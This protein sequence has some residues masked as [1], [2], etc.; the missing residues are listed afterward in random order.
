MITFSI[1]GLALLSTATSFGDRCTSGT[2]LLWVGIV[3]LLL[4]RNPKKARQHAAHI[5][6]C[7]RICEKVHSS[8]KTKYPEKWNNKKSIFISI[9]TFTYQCIRTSLTHMIGKFH[10][11]SMFAVGDTALE[12]SPCR[13]GGNDNNQTG[14]N[15][16]I[17]LLILS[18]KVTLGAN[19]R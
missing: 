17:C 8:H 12:R 1:R 6:I 4:Q 2:Y 19:S 5:M 11:A 16:P 15:G 7:D 9:I 14:T 10:L 18:T 3:N 13:N